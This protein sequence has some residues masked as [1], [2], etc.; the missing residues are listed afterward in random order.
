MEEFSIAVNGGVLQSRRE[1][2]N[3]K[4]ISSKRGFECLRV[5]RGYDLYKSLGDVGMCI[6]KSETGFLSDKL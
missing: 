5:A 4:S 1:D 6:T 2:D 3:A